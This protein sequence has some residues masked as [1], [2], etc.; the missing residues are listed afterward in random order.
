MFWE[1]SGIDSEVIGLMWNMS[2]FEYSTG[3]FF[4]GLFI[5]FIVLFFS[6]PLGHSCL[7]LSF[8]TVVSDYYTRYKLHQSLGLRSH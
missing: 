2:F 7:G 5:S 6:S 8:L 3:L 4:L 1:G